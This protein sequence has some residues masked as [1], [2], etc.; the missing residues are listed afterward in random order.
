[1]KR[2]VLLGLAIM[3]GCFFTGGFYIIISMDAVTGKLEKVI[4]FHQVEFLRVNLENHVKSVQA[5]L[6]LQDSPHARSLDTIS[7]HLE[8]METSANICQNCHHEEGT[9]HQLGVME[10]SVH[11]Y[12]QKINRALSVQ[13]S[14]QQIS[15]VRKEAFI[16]GES[17]LEMVNSLSIAS[18]KRIAERIE[19]IRLDVSRA[20]RL[21]VAL[22]VLGPL[23]ILI[24]T[25]FFLRRFTGSIDTLMT[26]TKNLEVGNLDY[27]IPASLKDEFGSLAGS[28]N[29]MALS[30][31]NKRRELESMQKLYQTLFESAGDA[32]CI[33]D[34]EGDNLG[35]IVSA[36][37][38]AEK[39][40]G[41]SI[42][43]LQSINTRDLTPD[44]NLQRFKERLTNIFAGSW[45]HFPV[46]R[47]RK[48]GSIFPAEL[49]VGLLEIDQHKYVL[50]FSRDI[51]D[52]RQAEQELLRANQM[53]IVGQMAAGL[54]HEIKNPLAG[55]KV[56]MEVLAD[57]LDLEQEDQELFARVIN[58]INRMERLLKNLLNFARP[59]QPQF[60][61]VDLNRL[62]DY[63][64][65]NVEVTAARTANKKI[66]FSR[67]LAADL[68]QIEAD[69]SQLQQVFLNIFLNAIEA[70]PKQGEISVQT[71]MEDDG[72][73]RI[74]IADNGRGMPEATVEKIF[75]PFFTTKSKGT[76]LGLAI[77]RRLI[78]QHEG[79]IDVTSQPEQGTTFT[80]LLPQT[81]RDGE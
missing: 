69:S 30:L 7:Q 15:N 73:I 71:R 66:S 22:V 49:S 20:K 61:L 50:S 59:P 6:L 28:F 80:I 57:E 48:D 10:Q 3:L 76:G 40:Y 77:C 31:K 11:E 38:A 79:T 5:D 24:I 17:L 78:E 67:S 12:M 18:A 4:A 53:A 8:N 75:N 81:Q 43:E 72:R 21:I 56:S 27:R 68:R 34:T 65:K 51:T 16:H 35:R 62:L 58:E 39:L 19:R 44:N 32:I 63:T 70:M 13:G 37:K 14:R 33:V 36:N 55:I 25:A 46:D 74:E 60:D 9:A 52:R 29:N 47:K 2:Y 64:I 1:M 42:E 26:A 41:Y 45:L 23:A 54:A